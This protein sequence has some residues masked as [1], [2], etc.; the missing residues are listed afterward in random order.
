[1][2]KF[3]AF[4]LQA[5]FAALWAD[6]V[7]VVV[8]EPD[9]VAG[10]VPE[11]VMARGERHA[12]RPRPVLAPLQ[13]VRARLPAVERAHHADRAG[14][15]VARQAKGDPGLVAEE[16]ALLDHEDLH[17]ARTENAARA[18]IPTTG[19]RDTGDGTPHTIGTCLRN[20]RTGRTPRRSPSSTPPR[21]TG[22]SSCAARF[23]WSSRTAS[24]SISMDSTRTR[25]PGICGSNGQG[26]SSRT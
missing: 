2:R 15:D 20:P 24:I 17:A 21:C 14:R 11:G 13:L 4:W 5:E 25:G 1:M 23:S 8:I 22:S 6:R 10:Q 12:D 9:A 7:R 16:P 19:G 26:K 3:P 18:S